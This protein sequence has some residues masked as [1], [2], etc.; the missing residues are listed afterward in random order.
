MARIQPTPGTDGTGGDG[1]PTGGAGRRK[2]VRYAVPVAVAGVAAATIGIGSALANTGD[3]DLPKISAQD[4]I[5]KMAQSDTQR[6]SGSVKISTDLGLPSLPS[7]M[8]FGTGGKG[9][10]HGRDGAEGAPAPSPESKLTELAAGTHTLRIAADGPD[11]QRLSV[12]ERAAE[13]TVVHNGA[14]VWAY[15]SAT[16]TAYHSTSSEARKK[17]EA[18]KGLGDASPQELAKKALAAVDDTTAVTVDGTAKV[19][20]RDAYQLA[21]KPKQGDST[22]GAVRIAVDAKNG[23]PLRFTLSAKSGGKAVVDAGFTKVDFGKPA[24]STFSFTPPKGAKV[25]EA[26]AGGKSADRDHKGK[27]P[28]GLG[29]PGGL[30]GAGGDGSATNVSGKGWSSIVEIKAGK[31]FDK[32]AV[33]G[34]GKSRG[35]DKG[36]GDA[37]ALLDGFGSKVSGDFGSGRV[38]STKIINALMTDDGKVYVGAV[39]KD[40]LVKAANAAK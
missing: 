19:A 24:Q 29:L 38:F 31:G 13:Y 33:T 6:I 20:G 35:A 28:E 18:P 10:G 30:L 11:R 25:T 3:P 12:V 15:D 9:A 5:A 1:A 2:A 27:L 4:L 37:G 23:V 40:A 17:H 8:S 39:S 16:N 36:A 22:V 34:K 21:I 26:G 14:E 7:G 32:G